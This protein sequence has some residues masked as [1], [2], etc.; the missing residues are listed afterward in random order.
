MDTDPRPCGHR[1]AG[2]VFE[3]APFRLALLGTDR[4]AADTACGAR[5]KGTQPQSGAAGRNCGFASSAPG[6]AKPL[7]PEGGGR[8]AVGGAGPYGECAAA[9]ERSRVL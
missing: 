7:F 8:R 5:R 1:K 3:K 2:G 6:G 4:L 9:G